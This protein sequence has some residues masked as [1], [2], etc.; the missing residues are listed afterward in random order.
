M[1]PQ[2]RQET[3]PLSQP[4]D[5]SAPDC[6]KALE[7]FYESYLRGARNRRY[8]AQALGLRCERATAESY[9]RIAERAYKALKAS[10][11][12]PSTKVDVGSAVTG[13]EGS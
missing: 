13:T 8:A 1:N 3:S 11:T 6:S 10:Q 2:P 9:E 12:P 4:G 7:A 5:G